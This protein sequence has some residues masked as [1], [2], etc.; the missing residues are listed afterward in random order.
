LSQVQDRL[1]NASGWSTYDTWFGGGMIASS[2][3]HERMDEAAQAAATADQRLAVLRTELA[4]VGDPGL[5][6]PQLALSGG[7]KFV[8]VWFDNFFTDMAVA[9]RIR[10]AERQVAESAQTVD[11]LR[12]L[13]T[14]RASDMQARL[15]A[16]E[17][18]RDSLLTAR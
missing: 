1:G 15:N 10:Q 4:D 16:I 12:A 5:T 18:E 2:I 11:R 9:D 14:S 7:T 3:K 13:L 8:D 17:A 6:A